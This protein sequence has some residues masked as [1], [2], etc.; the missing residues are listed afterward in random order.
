MTPDSAPRLTTSSRFS[1]VAVLTTP[2][3]AELVRGRLE[4][5]GVEAFV[6]DGDI[7][8]ADWTM[9]NAV[10]GV[11]VRV[12]SEDADRAR[13]LL[14]EPVEEPDDYEAPTE[15]EALAQRALYTSLLGTIIPPVQ[16]Y[17]LYLLSCYWAEAGEETGRTR[18]LVWGAV[19][20]MVPSFVFLV[21]L[22]MD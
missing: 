4:E 1:T 7:V 14:A 21:F 15:I 17:T 19:A 20:L 12:A 6:A 16:V 18:R 5:N 9:S 13:N 10:G 8:T 11:K 3:E 2:L 22:L